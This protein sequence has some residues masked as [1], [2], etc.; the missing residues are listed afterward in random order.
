MAK[1]VYKRFTCRRCGTCCSDV[2]S[3]FWRRSDHELVRAIA[4]TDQP[5]DD[6]RRCQMLRM[7]NGRAECL[8]Q[9]YLGREAKPQ[10]CYDY[11][12]DGDSC[13][14]AERERR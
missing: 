11:P 10:A 14:R 4:A 9:K 2:G 5:T 8:L 12:F 7:R 6:G 13:R 3:G 1:Q